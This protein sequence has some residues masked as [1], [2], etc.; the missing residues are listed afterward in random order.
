MNKPI[1][2]AALLAACF[3]AS[4]SPETSSEESSASSE[5]S[6]GISLLTPSGAPTL[7][8]Y[9]MGSDE[10]W[11][12][13]SD[14]TSIPPSLKAN[15]Y[16]AIVFDGLNGLNVLKQGATNYK[17]AHWI[18]GGNFYVVSTTHAAGDAFEGD[19]TTL[20]FNQTGTASVAFNKLSREEWDWDYEDSQVTYLDGVQK[21]MQTLVQNPG[22]YDYYV[23]AEPVLTN[24]KNQLQAKNVTLNTIYNI[25]TEWKDAGLGETIPAA[26]LF[27]NVN[28]YAEK[29]DE[30][31]A[32]LERTI[33]RIDTA[34]EEPETVVAALNE[35]GDATAV[36]ARFGYQPNLVTALQG[37]GQDRFGL[38]SSETD[39]G[40]NLEFANAYQTAVGG[41]A[42]DASL[43]LF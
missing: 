5:E 6:E 21:V 7:A 40:T 28:S 37:N 12:S 3:L 34:I 11:V 31:D 27:F 30:M 26:G 4:C 13:T 33:E 32:F 17:L 23:I 16:D 25:Q 35:Y 1:A 18:T 41:A 15:E 8:F 24:A 10:N 20:S 9:D 14:A 43:F 38:I 42:Y 39:I 2:A 29:K 19:E 22:S 36:Q